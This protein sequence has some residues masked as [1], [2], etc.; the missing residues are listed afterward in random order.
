MH[1]PKLLGVAMAILVY[2]LLVS[3]LTYFSIAQVAHKCNILLRDLAFI[4][5][6]F[7]IGESYAPF[8][9]SEVNKMPDGQSGDT[10]PNDTTTTDDQRAAAQQIAK[11]MLDED[12]EFL[13]RNP[14]TGRH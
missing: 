9:T 13:E 4:R 2:P 7:I 11:D 3:L 14:P 6:P 10:K 12:H 8:E 5:K 1:W